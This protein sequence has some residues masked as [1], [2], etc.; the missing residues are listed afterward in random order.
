[1]HNDLDH[2]TLRGELPPGVIPA[3]DG[4]TLEIAP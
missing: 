1:M 3:H 2:A 4:L